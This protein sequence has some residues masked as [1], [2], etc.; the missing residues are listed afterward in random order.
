MWCCVAGLV[1]PDALKALCLFETSN[2]VGAPQSVK[3]NAVCSFET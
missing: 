3:L 2:N 1:F